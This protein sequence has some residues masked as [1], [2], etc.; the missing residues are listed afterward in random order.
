VC[1]CHNH[2]FRYGN[3]DGAALLVDTAVPSAIPVVDEAARNDKGVPPACSS[4]SGM[5]ASRVCV[6][7]ASTTAFG[8]IIWDSSSITDSLTVLH[9]LYSLIG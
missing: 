3:S 8:G 6:C 1:Q 9:G 4:A 7:A 2:A 5:R